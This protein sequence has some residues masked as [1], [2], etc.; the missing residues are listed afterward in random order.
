ML[1][2]KA[3]IELKIKRDYISSNESFYNRIS[4]NYSLMGSGIEEADLL[5]V[6]TSPPEIFIGEGD[7]TTVAGNTVIHNKNEE[8]LTILNN[9][10]NRIVVNANLPLT[11]QDRVYISD[12]LYK[13]GIRNDA[14][15]MK[16]VRRLREENENTNS[17]ITEYLLGGEEARDSALR[18]YVSSFI[19]N[20]ERGGDISGERVRESTLSRE[21]MDRLHTG[22][23]YQILSN[24]N[25]SLSETYINRNEYLLSEQAQTAREILAQRFLE[26][27][28]GD[29]GAFVF[30]NENIY[31]EEFLSGETREER[32]NSNINAAVLVNM[33]N[34]LLTTGYERLRRDYNK[35]FE[36]RDTFYHSGDNTLVRLKTITAD[37]F[38]ETVREQF[39]GEAPIEFPAPE[40]G[41][42]PGEI[43]ETNREQILIRQL[44]EINE[45][46]E[47]N[48]EKYH[49]M[50]TI[51][52]RV[53]GRRG[54]A[55]GEKRTLD[56]ARQ[57]LRSEAGIADKLREEEDRSEENESRA[58]KE[59]ERLFPDEYKHIYEILNQYS[60]GE[61]NTENNSL[62]NMNIS[63]LMQDIE[64]VRLENLKEDLNY[65]EI[66][67]V[68]LNFLSGV[69]EIIEGTMEE[70]NP[71]GVRE[72][73]ERAEVRF[74]E[75]VRSE[76]NEIF[77]RYMENID[78]SG[79]SYINRS[80]IQSLI[81]DIDEVF[82]ESYGGELIIKEG[83]RREN[84]SERE[85]RTLLEIEERLGVRDRS[86]EEAVLNRDEG[87][88]LT[89][90]DVYREAVKN[91]TETVENRERVIER[92]READRELR[93]IGEGGGAPEGSYEDGDFYEAPITHKT[94][95]TLTREEIEETLDEFRRE[96]GR[97]LETRDTVI[98][99]SERREN[100]IRTG[101][102]NVVNLTEHQ[103]EDIAALVDRGVRSRMDTIS[104]E[105]MHRL[106]KR[107][108]NE[109]AR[110][111]I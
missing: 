100:I 21:I 98:E 59:I 93:R 14:F 96:T 110:R 67:Q 3:P 20:I 104:N 36:F 44:Q 43:R 40:E 80:N 79:V 37:T 22:A 103:I 53:R 111:G 15:F 74:P 85:L 34:N 65:R 77:S 107:L 92:Q 62:T 19:Q 84:L 18:Q 49:R 83:L 78:N 102:E 32:V 33:I 87:A 13:L 41:E 58:F 97:R 52:E 16:E 27:I 31:E 57:F 23:I 4:G 45:R 60:A 25:S 1:I 68:A 38:Y 108:V 30:R 89:H 109:K 64:S 70:Q 72:R 81:N 17:F 5:H 101:E 105:V 2:L 6:V 88:D 39:K 50:L 54:R 82:L 66:D 28:T 90:P 12:V 8:K 106:E 11:Y 76:V 48:L 86:G 9:L 42:E 47:R 95:E 63:S 29:R 94:N 75:R 55:D 73:L 61:R 69:H 71:R 56:A 35:W 91:I 7:I 26:R 99:S 24:F 46:N 10:L 51:L